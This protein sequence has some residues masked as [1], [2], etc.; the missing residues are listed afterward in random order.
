[1]AAPK[2]QEMELLESGV[3]SIGEPCAPV[4]VS[5]YGK[6][7]KVQTIATG[8]KFRLLEIR[9]KFLQKHET[10]MRLHTNDEVCEILTKCNSYNTANYASATTEE[11]KQ[12]V[13]RVRKL[14]GL[15]LPALELLGGLS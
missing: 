9:K 3:I 8:Q 11:L 1:M 6:G 12:Q 2:K 7:V 15:P 14:V 5:R 4:T 10:F 13:I